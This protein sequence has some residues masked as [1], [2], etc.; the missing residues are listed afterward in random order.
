MPRTGRTSA[1]PK[2]LVHTGGWGDA[3]G[4]D[5]DTVV[6]VGSVVEGQLCLL[7]QLCACVGSTVV[8]VGSAVLCVVNVCLVNC[9]VCWVL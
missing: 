2:L 3:A 7:G 4:E 5:N 8:C 6:C 9:G 1:P